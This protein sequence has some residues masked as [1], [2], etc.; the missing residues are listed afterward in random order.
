M[1]AMVY[2]LL[3]SSAYWLLSLS[4]INNTGQ[5]NFEFDTNDLWPLALQNTSCINYW[6]S[7]SN[8]GGRAHWLTDTGAK[9]K[10]DWCGNKVMHEEAV[11]Q[12]MVTK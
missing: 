6:K 7:K 12:E 4:Y 1:Q 3:Q 5:T 9:F 10:M 11:G 8:M 2:L